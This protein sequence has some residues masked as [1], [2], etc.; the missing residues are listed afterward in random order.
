MKAEHIVGLLIVLV[1]LGIAF[2]ALPLHDQQIKNWA[3]ENNYKLIKYEMTIGDYGPF[4]VKGQNQ[5]IYRI[6]VDDGKKYRIF[7]MR[8]GLVTEFEEYHNE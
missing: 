7:Y 3:Q 4:Y 6:E 8:T 5:Y 2:I 1:L